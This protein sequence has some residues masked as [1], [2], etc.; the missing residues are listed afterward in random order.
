MQQALQLRTGQK[1]GEI[2]LFL[3]KYYMAEEF[4]AARLSV[5]LKYAPPSEFMAEQEI[6]YIETRQGIRYEENQRLAIKMSLE[7]GIMVLTGGPGTGKTTTLNAMIK[8]LAGKGLEIA[9]AAPTGRAAK[10]MSELTGCEAKT[11]H[12]LLEVEWDENDRQKFARN[13]K[14]PLSCDVLIIDEMSM[15]DV[16]LF[17]AVLRALRL[18]CRLIMVGDADQLPSVGAGNVLADVLEAGCV[19]AIRLSKVFRQAMESLIISNAHRIIAGEPPVLDC[20]TSDFFMLRQADSFNAGQLVCELCAERLPRAYGFNPITDIQVL[21]PSRMMELGSRNLNNLLQLRLNPLKKGMKKI[22]FKGFE[23]R[24]GDKVMQ[25]KNNYDILWT[26]DS[27][28]N[29]SGVFNGD[30]G[31]LEKIDPPSGVVQ[32]R[33]DDRLATYYNENLGELDLAYAM[34]IHKS[35]GS[36]FECVILP[37]LD[38]PQKL[39][40]RNL[41]YT[42]V[43]RAKRLLIAVGSR[44]LLQKMVQNNRKTL[45]YTS[46]TQRLAESFEKNV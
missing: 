27:G 9:L 19:P 13:E 42:A 40:Y 37:V 18:G 5:L 25:I 22:V 23:L 26:A 33:F 4:I 3:P 6:D 17:E 29:G 11:I 21:C 1:N 32:V 44:E 24:E 35:Q 7:N 30:I 38:A 15:V 34:T 12:R 16:L 46:L 45:R 10:R 36:E 2:F 31:I 41:L 28:E 14:N 8:I 20:K 39:L 43:T